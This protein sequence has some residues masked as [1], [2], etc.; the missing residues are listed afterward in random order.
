MADI[1]RATRSVVIQAL[2]TVI[3]DLT[4]TVN[5]LFFFNYSFNS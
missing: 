4:D 2:N 1:H 5:E 3:W